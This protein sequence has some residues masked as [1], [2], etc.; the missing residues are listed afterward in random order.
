MAAVP[1][2]TDVTRPVGETV[3]TPVFNDCQVTARPVSVL[4]A[5]SLTVAASWIV[6]PRVTV[7]GVGATVTDA[8]GTIA[9][10]IVAVPDLVP[11]VPV[12]V[13][14]PDPAAVTVAVSGPVALTVAMPVAPLWNVTVDPGIALPLASVTTAVSVCCCP[15][16]KLADCGEI[17]TALIGT[18]C[19]VNGTD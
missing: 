14:C 2:L 9:T 11:L 6:L 3:A 7:S 4:P 19:T 1:T 5:E 8:T 10:L 16:N 12:I 17:T 13:A 15:T 18:A